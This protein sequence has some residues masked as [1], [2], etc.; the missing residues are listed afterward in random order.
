M[1]ETR[2]YPLE[3]HSDGEEGEAPPETHDPN[4]DVNYPWLLLGPEQQ[5]IARAWRRTFIFDRMG[6]DKD[7]AA[8]VL[9]ETMSAVDVWLEGG[10]IPGATRTS[11][12]SVVR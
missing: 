2:I 10:R 8:G 9:I 3:N 7:W 4:I 11:A 12:L 6:A 1:K 5:D